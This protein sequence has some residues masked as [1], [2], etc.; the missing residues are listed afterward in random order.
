MRYS[1][2]APINVLFR[3]NATFLLI[4]APFIQQGLHLISAVL[5][6]SQS[7]G[8]AYMPFL[9]EKGRHIINCRR[10]EGELLFILLIF[11]TVSNKQRNYI[12]K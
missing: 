3:G 10:R 9:M 5:S 1:S 2:T 6:E 4:V 11:Y 7:L 12:P 8:P